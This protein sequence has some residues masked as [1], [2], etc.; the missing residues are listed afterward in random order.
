MRI[1]ACPPIGLVAPTVFTW[2]KVPICESGVYPDKFGQ[3]HRHMFFH[4]KQNF[5]PI[6][7]LLEHMPFTAA[8]FG[9]VSALYVEGEFLLGDMCFTKYGVEALKEYKDR[10]MGCGWS[11]GVLEG[12]Q[13][14]GE[15][16][17]CRVPRV[18]STHILTL[19]DVNL[20][21]RD[22][23]KLGMRDETGVCPIGDDLINSVMEIV[24]SEARGDEEA[25]LASMLK[26]Q[27]IVSDNGVVLPGF[28]N[29]PES[30]D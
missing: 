15:V 17:L 2:E 6:P 3:I 1:I 4:W 7:I 8:F 28:E 27:K 29:E 10:H 25:L 18:S 26:L 20:P 16:T 22:M 21:T 14:L 13:G 19:K 5:A 12:R 30:V 9:Y 23:S 11:V 24:N